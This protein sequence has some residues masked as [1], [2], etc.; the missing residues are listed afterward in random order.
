MFGLP[1]MPP[2]CPAAQPAAGQTDGG[3]KFT[4]K[5][6]LQGFVSDVQWVWTDTNPT[7]WRLEKSFPSNNHWTLETITGPLVRNVSGLLGNVWYR[8]YGV[9]TNGVRNTQIS[10]S[11]QL[12][13]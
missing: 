9:D 8:V 5:P 6:K 10:N 13:P 7:N 4:G 11:V 2:G 3:V 1:S 12:P